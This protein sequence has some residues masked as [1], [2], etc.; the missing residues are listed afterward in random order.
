MRNS[1]TIL[2][3]WRAKTCK[4]I[5]RV[6]K[7]MVLQGECGNEKLIRKSIKMIPESPSSPNPWYNSAKSMLENVMRC[8][9]VLGAFR[10]RKRNYLNMTLNIVPKATQMQLE[11]H[12]SEPRDLQKYFVRHRAKKVKKRGH[13]FVPHC[14]TFS[15]NSIKFDI[16]SFWKI[17]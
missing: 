17:K 10:C 5:G 8:L 11:R 3:F 4:F 13:L 6:I 12:Q 15:V 16:E 9:R 1:G 7:F 2:L 14:E